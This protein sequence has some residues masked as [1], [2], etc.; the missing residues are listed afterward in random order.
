MKRAIVLVF[1]ILIAL[2]TLSASENLA[3]TLEGIRVYWFGFVPT[4][5][6]LRLT[7]LGVPLFTGLDTK[8]FFQAGGGY[9]EATVWRNSDGTVYTGPAPENREINFMQPN[10]RFETGIIQGIAWNQELEKNLLEAFLIYRL[11]YDR[12]MPN[13]F[14]LIETSIFQDREGIFSNSL[15]T[16]LVFNNLEVDK[17]H[18]TKNGLYAEASLEW[19]PPFLFNDIFGYSDYVR[20]NTSVKTFLKILDLNQYDEKNLLSIYLG[21]YFSADLIL[22]N[23]IPLFVSQSFGGTKLRRS[24]GGSVRGFEKKAWDGNLKLVNNFEIR[25]NGPALFLPSLV[26]GLLVYLDAGYAADYFADAS[27]SPSFLAATGAGVYLNVFDFDYVAVYFQVPLL[28][29][30]KDEK[31]WAIAVELGLHF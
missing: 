22:G 19:A 31:P 21:N 20:L 30:R 17:A 25:V 9:E 14:S 6:D 11:R 8:L 29:Q 28:G 2:N 12:N 24:L 3:V 7:Y 27:A 18:K 16:G 15:F 13:D 5:V 23:V 26:P 10:A 4:G 1:L